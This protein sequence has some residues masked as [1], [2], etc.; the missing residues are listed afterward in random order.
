M[1][2][3]AALYAEVSSYQQE[4]GEKLVERLS[5]LRG[6]RVLD[7][8]C[9]TGHLASV[10][11]ELVGVEGSVTGVDPDTER[12]CLA[13]EAYGTASNLQ[14]LKGMTS[15]F[16][17]AR[18]ISCFQTTSCTGSQTRTVCSEMCLQT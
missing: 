7:L 15:I 9:G 8:G 13:R 2:S 5:P 17:P 6:Y 16:R 14:F 3:T 1:T 4:D 12:V 18:T 11:A 10:M